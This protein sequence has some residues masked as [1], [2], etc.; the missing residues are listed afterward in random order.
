MNTGRR[1]TGIAAGTV[2]RGSDIMVGMRAADPSRV[3][4]ASLG[5]RPNRGPIESSGVRTECSATVDY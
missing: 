4:H 2:V 3:Y 1:R 5:G